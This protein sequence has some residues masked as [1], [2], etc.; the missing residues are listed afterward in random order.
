MNIITETDKLDALTDYLCSI[1][2]NK[3][4]PYEDGMLSAIVSYLLTDRDVEGLIRRYRKGH[5]NELELLIAELFLDECSAIT[6]QELI[7]DVLNSIR[8]QIGQLPIKG[9][10]ARRGVIIIRVRS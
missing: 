7:E 9:L 6:L 5:I 2:P 10:E 4:C 8:Q 1:L 3:D